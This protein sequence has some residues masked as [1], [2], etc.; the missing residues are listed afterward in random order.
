MKDFT[1]S[2]EAQR[3]IRKLERAAS[4]KNIEARDAQTDILKAV[5]AEMERLDVPANWT[6]NTAT[7]MFTPPTP[8]VIK[9][10]AGKA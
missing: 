2:D 10:E 1:A 4:L 5:V 6:Y 9:K 8:E 3:A 7:G